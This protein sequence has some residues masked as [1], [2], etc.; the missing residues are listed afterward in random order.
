M[1][2]SSFRKTP[3]PRVRTVHTPGTGRG[4]HAQSSD[5]VVSVPKERPVRS[6][7][8]RR[9]VATLPCYRCGMHGHSQ[10][11]H[12]DQGKG[13]A[14]KSS[15]LTCYPLCGP[16]LDQRTTPPYQMVPGCHADVGTLGKMTQ[17][18]RRDFESRAIPDTQF[19]LMLMSDNE[20]ALRTLLTKLGLLP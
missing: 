8:Y 11:A 4:V 13:M 16:H 18:E 1:Q 2:R 6:A 17:A 10:A 12:A 20:R 3:P 15:D 5:E 19:W 7:D 9:W 14:I